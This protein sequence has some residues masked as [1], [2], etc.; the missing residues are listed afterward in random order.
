MLINCLDFVENRK[1]ILQK[2]LKVLKSLNITP[3]L[4]IINTDNDSASN[5]YIK[6]KVSFGESLG[7]KVD[8]VNFEDNEKELI[9]FIKTLNDNDSVH[10]IIV[11][12]PLK[13]GL[14]TSKVLNNI[15]PNKD[16]DC[17]TNINKAKFYI[18]QEYNSNDLIPATAKG[19]WELL[20]EITKNQLSGKKVC[21]INRS[22]L[23][24]KPLMEL[25]NF[26]NCTVTLCHSK[27]INI[28]E[29]TRISDII[30]TGS[31]RINSIESSDVRPN[32]IIIDVSINK[33]DNNN[34]VGDANLEDLKDYCNITP[35][36]GGIGP[37][38]VYEVFNNLI[39]LIER[40]LYL[41]KKIKLPLLKLLA[42]NSK[43]TKK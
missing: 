26:E 7:I 19:I 14:D 40:D 35:V 18:K 38:T 43:K 20:K 36:P 23:V 10:G 34:I 12:L 28:Y 25:L 11:Q 32:T 9:N 41:N 31:K 3:R 16:V 24:G 1:N 29:F 39:L 6:R 15:S 5:S 30:I 33:N 8:V 27:T 2:K 4:V 13:E 22:E 17:L 42:T 37:I 21:L